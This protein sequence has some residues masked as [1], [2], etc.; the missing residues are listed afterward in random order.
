MLPGSFLDRF[1]AQFQPQDFP[2]H[3]DEG[4]DPKQR[5]SPHPHAPN[6]SLNH[7]LLQKL[8]SQGTEIKGTFGPFLLAEGGWV[9]GVH[10]QT[11]LCPAMSPALFC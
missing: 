3:T 7:V 11:E 10:L 6:L 4:S 8:H 1:F 2:P 5:P 9:W